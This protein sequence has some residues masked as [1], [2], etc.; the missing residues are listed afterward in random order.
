MICSIE[1]NVVSKRN[2]LLRVRIFGCDVMEKTCRDL[3]TV[4]VCEI[5]QE[6]SRDLLYRSKVVSKRK[7]VVGV[8]SIERTV[9]RKREKLI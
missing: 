1:S 7:K 3:S 5:K 4:Y 2:E 8:C 9:L 6:T